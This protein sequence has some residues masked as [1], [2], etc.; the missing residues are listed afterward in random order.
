MTDPP[1]L[2][3]PRDGSSLSPEVYEADIEID[4]CGQ[5]GGVWL[6]KGELEQIQR[7]VER[8][9]GSLLDRPHD[10]TGGLPSSPV[11]RPRIS[12]PKCAAEMDARPYGMGSMVVID[13]CPDGCGIWLDQGEL[14]ALEVLFERGQ[15]EAQIPLHWRLWASVVERLRRRG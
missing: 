11:P 12:C 8:D 2:S 6:D 10:P 3:C 13:V 4:A 5:C 7:T 14:E 15:E 1:G 9:H